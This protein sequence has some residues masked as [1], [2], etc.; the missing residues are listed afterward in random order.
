MP[1]L[2]ERYKAVLQTLKA[3]TPLLYYMHLVFVGGAMFVL[4]LALVNSA[5]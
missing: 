4:L 3:S 2:V 5:F 1:A